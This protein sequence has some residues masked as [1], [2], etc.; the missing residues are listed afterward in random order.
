MTFLNLFSGP[1][2][3][4]LKARGD[5]LFAAR[6]W[7]EAALAYERALTRLDR[8]PRPEESG[9]R[10]EIE[11]KHSRS[12]EALA[13]EHR[14]T[15]DRYLEG[16]YTREA[17]EFL[18]LAMEISGDDRF[19]R[20]LKRQLDQ[21][22]QDEETDFSPDR[23]DS[24]SLEHD[25]EG[26][27][28]LVAEASGEETFFALCQT[29]PPDVR[30]RYLSYG[31]D[32]M[33]GYL[34]LNAG[35]FHR[36]AKWLARAMAD[37]P[38]PGSYIALE[39]ATAL[40]HLGNSNEAEALLESVVARHPDALPAYEL[41]CDLYWS[42]EDFGRARTLLEALP[43][44]LENSVAAVLLTGETFH[45]S[46]HLETARDLYRKA[47]DRYG[48][49]EA[50]AV[51]LAG[52][53]E[54]MKD[55]SGARRLYGELMRRCRSCRSP[56]DP[57]IRHRYAELAFADGLFGTE[58]LE[59]YLLLAKEVPDHRALYFSRISRIYAAA[60]DDGEAKRFGTLAERARADIRDEI[61]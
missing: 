25:F 9:L 11:E 60:G 17:R 34:A 1:S 38:D 35:D 21:L 43:P 40:V 30:D 27:D 57:V 12:R 7:G 3:E 2:P 10:K 54:D 6:Q 19:R 39:L 52:T 26:N 37:H 15:A 56:V 44:V 49:N 32:F 13:R 18:L 14:S 61:D 33:N 22:C 55:R 24:G 23:L 51:A 50:I 47:L 42:R 8:G 29:L 4:K 31:D 59:H 5:A 16:G 53:F 58:I 36:A 20:H 28:N 46:G 48:W 45:R 41:L